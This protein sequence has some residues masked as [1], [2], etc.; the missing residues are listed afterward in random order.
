MPVGIGFLNVFRCVGLE[1]FGR[2]G[3]KVEIEFT[4]D[5][6][7]CLWIYTGSLAGRRQTPGSVPAVLRRIPL[8][9]GGKKIFISSA[10]K[11]PFGIVPF[12]GVFALALHRPA[13]GMIGD[14]VVAFDGHPEKRCV[15]LFKRQARVGKQE[16]GRDDQSNPYG[17]SGCY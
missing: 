7:E 2:F 15:Y 16:D 6:F 13:L 1:L 3:A 12:V 17:L 8:R 9:I 5:N 10:G 4:V 14:G 11:I